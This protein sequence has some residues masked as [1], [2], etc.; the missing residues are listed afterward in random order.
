MAFSNSFNSY[1]TCDTKLSR[2]GDKRSHLRRRN[3]AP[4]REKPPVYCVYNW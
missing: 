2:Y 1:K 3:R 4:N